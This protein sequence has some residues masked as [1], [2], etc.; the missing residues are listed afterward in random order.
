[1]LVVT[2]SCQGVKETVYKMDKPY[3]ELLKGSIPFAVPMR[4]GNEV[5]GFQFSPDAKDKKVKL[6]LSCDWERG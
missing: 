1:M 4:V 6:P 5:D 3:A 2:V